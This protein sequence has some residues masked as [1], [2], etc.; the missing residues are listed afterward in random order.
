MIDDDT[1][2]DAAFS[3]GTHLL[4]IAP[5]GCGKT[6]LLAMRAEA[7]IPRLRPNQRILALTFSNRARDNLAERMRTH[8]GTKRFRRFVRVR[9]FHGHATE[10]ITAHCRTIRLDPEFTLPTKQLLE[11]ALRAESGDEDAIAAAKNALSAAKRHPRTDDE[12]AAALDVA[13]SSLAISIERARARTP[14]LHYDDLLRH[15][16]RLLRVDEVANLYQQHYGAVLVDEFQD[17]SPQQLDLALR[18]C[19]RNRTFVGDPL[20]GIYTWAGANPAAVEA[21]L[22]ALC[23]E[24][25]RLTRSYRSSPAVLTMLNSVGVPLG[26]AA[27]TSATPGAWPGG[28]AAAAVAFPTG[29]AEASWITA[30][31]TN[32]LERRPE[33]TIGVIARSGWRRKLINAAFAAQPK[34]PCRHWD[35]AVDDRETTERLQR[36]ASALPRTATFAALRE[37]AITDL[38]PNDV[39]GRSD[40]EEAIAEIE[41][42]SQGEQSIRSAIRRYLRDDSDQAI[43]PGVH[44][45]NAHTGKGQQF[46]WVFVPGLEKGHV[47]DFRAQG[48]GERLEERR[49]LLVMLSRAKEGV[50]VSRAAQLISRR[51]NSYSTDPS[52]WWPELAA[53]A[54]M[55]RN[56]FEA[57]VTALSE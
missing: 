37:K 15:A 24:P 4:V 34:L 57:A 6:E 43:A 11:R 44:L 28:D 38:D 14:Q 41:A 16:Q 8:L 12:V 30:R 5:P 33:A 46:D 25:L 19:L 13:G 7:L 47:P 36:A 50:A 48:T 2:R 3:E 42:S 26:A 17:L 56:Q 45:L 31:C 39:D 29:I 35:L 32:I 49:V 22:T 53:A 51:G 10:I 20:Q 9:N 55:S 52:P 40:I 18:T 54:A 23:G 27:L 1:Q 21:E